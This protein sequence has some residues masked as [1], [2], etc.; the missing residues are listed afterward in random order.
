MRTSMFG[1]SMILTDVFS[2][3]GRAKGR[4][5]RSIGASER[6]QLSS[7]ER[8]DEARMEERIDVVLGGWPRKYASSIAMRQRWGLLKR[9]GYRAEPT[10]AETKQEGLS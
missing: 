2:C 1:H 5:G 6:E 7:A 8:H 10:P 4:G 9:C 3:A